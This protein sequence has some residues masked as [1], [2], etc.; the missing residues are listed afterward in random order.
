MYTHHQHLVTKYVSTEKCDTPTSHTGGFHS[1]AGFLSSV[2]MS[3]SRPE[4]RWPHRTNSMWQTHRYEE[5][6]TPPTHLFCFSFSFLILSNFLITDPV[7]GGGG[8]KPAVM[9]QE[10]GHLSRKPVTP[11]DGL[12]AAVNLTSS[13]DT[14]TIYSLFAFILFSLLNLIL[15]SF[16]IFSVLLWTDYHQWRAA[17]L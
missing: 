15:F 1:T 10:A 16:F 17:P 7:Q 11:A 6:E 13:K 2:L 12:N 8:A 5:E 4:V 14:Q 9:R 3:V